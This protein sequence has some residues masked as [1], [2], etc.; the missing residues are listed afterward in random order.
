MNHALRPLVLPVAALVCALVVL[1]AVP[2]RS[3]SGSPVSAHI[4]GDASAP[5][6]FVVF[7]A[8][9]RGGLCDPA[10][11]PGAV[12]LHPVLNLP[13]EFVIE[14]GD[15]AI[16]ATSSLTAIPPN[17][18]AVSGVRTFSTA[19]NAAAGSPI[20]AFAPLAAG[21]TDECQAWIQVAQSIPGPLRVL[22]TVQS[23]EGTLRWVADLD[24]RRTAAA[25]L[26]F[27]WSLITWAGADGVK[28]AE[29]LASGGSAKEAV[30]AIYGWAAASQTW[31]AFFPAAAAVPGANDLAT[32]KAG[33]AYWVAVRGP[34]GATWVMK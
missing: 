2:A 8:L 21:V 14:S 33:T 25:T 9:D 10:R 28:P 3:E 30:T 29:A 11:V 19:K 13:V 22:V 15:G 32:L 5:F 12:S 31:L 27:R 4:E 20:R 34:G 18:R 7:H 17:P 24:T 23:D 26:N 1:G 16:I 6:V